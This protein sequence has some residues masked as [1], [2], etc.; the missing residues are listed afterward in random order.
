MNYTYVLLNAIFLLPLLIMLVARR[1]QLNRVRTWQTLSALCVLTVIF[2]NLMVA[3]GIMAYSH[4]RILGLQLGLIPIEDFA[5]TLATVLL[6][7][8]L[9]DRGA[10]P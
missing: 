4:T 7:A 1:R 3:A 6:V 10:K 8:L 2:D 9:W 5:Y